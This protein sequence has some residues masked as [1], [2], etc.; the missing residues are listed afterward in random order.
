MPSVEEKRVYDASDG[1]REVVAA[2]GLGV[3]RVSV[4]ADL[5]GEFGVDHRCVARDVA[6]ADGRVFAAADDVYCDGEPT[7]HGPAVGVGVDRGSVIA[8]A[9]DGTV[10]R[11]SVDALTTGNA[12]RSTDANA[13]ANALETAE[14]ASLGE[15]DDVRCVAGRLVGT[16]TGVVRAGDDLQPTGLSDVRALTARVPH[17][18]TAD[19]WYK[20]D[21]GCHR[22][23][24]G[25]Q[26][27]GGDRFVDGAR[28]V[29]AV[30]DC[31]AVATREAIHTRDWWTDGW[32][33]H[34]RRDV[35]ALAGANETLFALDTDGRLHVSV[36]DGWRDRALGVTDP[37]ALAVCD[38]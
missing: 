8:V 35:L 27:V 2:T 19:G 17:A 20:L 34:E 12:P 13:T 30:G 21:D 38:A 4:S 18:A 7:A 6:V 28:A 15:L 36:G 16:G 9:P 5:I 37:A 23:G 33:R 3:V 14:W 31:V 29:T 32:T 25:W 26:R 1:G 11:S 22:L 24:N 10:R